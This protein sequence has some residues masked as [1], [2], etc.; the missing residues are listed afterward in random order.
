[1]SKIAEKQPIKQLEVSIK[2]TNDL[3][4]NSYVCATALLQNAPQQTLTTP[5]TKSLF[6]M[7]KSPKTP[8]KPITPVAVLQP[9]MEQQEKYPQSEVSKL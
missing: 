5:V 9:L 4:D 8:N 1:M 6:Q 3:P 7:L 2:D